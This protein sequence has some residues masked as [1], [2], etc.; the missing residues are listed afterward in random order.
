MPGAVDRPYW[1]KD[2]NFDVS[3]SVLEGVDAVRG[4]LSGEPASAVLE[5]VDTGLAKGWQAALSVERD[6]LVWLR[7]RPAGKSAIEAFFARSSGGS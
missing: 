4:E 2:A 6:R 5:A 7:S 3:S 1:V